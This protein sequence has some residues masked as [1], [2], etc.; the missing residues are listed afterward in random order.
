[1]RCKLFAKSKR[2]ALG[3]YPVVEFQIEMRA[4]HTVGNLLRR[5][6]FHSEVKYSKKQ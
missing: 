5:R 3:M 4:S 2:S 6:V 1:M